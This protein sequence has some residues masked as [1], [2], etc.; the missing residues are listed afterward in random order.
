[1]E[2]VEEMHK[3]YLRGNFKK[4][5]VFHSICQSHLSFYN[6]SSCMGIFFIYLFM[7]I[8]W[9]NF[10]ILAAIFIINFCMLYN[11]EWKLNYYAFNV[12]IFF[13]A[14]KMLHLTWPQLFTKMAF[15]C[16]TEIINF[17]QF[18]IITGLQN[19]K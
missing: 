4:H 10:N 6:G 8:F 11:Y 7:I 1:M 2:I 13:I 15:A 17:E 12:F 5:V 19:K 14:R 18:S 3:Y 16:R 9:L